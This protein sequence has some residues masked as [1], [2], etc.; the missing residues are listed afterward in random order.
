MDES[1]LLRVVV[2]LFCVVLL[3]LF[4]AW[5]SK[6]QGWLKTHENRRIKIIASQRLGARASLLIVSIDN[7]EIVLGVTPQQINL[8]HTLDD[9]KSFQQHLNEANDP[10]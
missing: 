9:K 2:S 1:S 7:T 3:I 6:R 10:S 8:L 4:A 5:L